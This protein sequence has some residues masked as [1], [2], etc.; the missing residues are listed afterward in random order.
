MPNKKM[1]TPRVTIVAPAQVMGPPPRPRRSRNIRTRLASVT[2]RAVRYASQTRRSSSQGDRSNLVHDDG[3]IEQKIAA[4]EHTPRTRAGVAFI[5]R[6]LNP[7]GED[8]TPGFVG[9]PDASGADSANLEHRDDFIL[10]TPV[11]LDN[12]EEQSTIVIFNTPYFM[13]HYIAI[14][15]FGAG[16]SSIDLQNTVNAPTA[17]QQDGPARYPNW[18]APTLVIN[19]AGVLIS[20]LGPAFEITFLV[21]TGFSAFTSA[22]GAG[23]RS[24]AWEW[25]R[26]WRYVC[27]GSTMHLNAPG[28]ANQGR[29]ISAAT[30]TESSWKNVNVVTGSGTPA[31]NVSVVARFT[32]SPPFQDNTLALQDANAHQD[33]AKKG[34]YTIQRHANEAIIWNEAEDVRPIW[35]TS[36][37]AV[38]GENGASVPSLP[39]LKI[40]GFDGNMGWIVQH[41]RGLSQQAS[42]HLKTRSVIAVTAP[43]TSPWALIMR[44]IVSKDQPALVLLKELAS[45]LP[46]SF[47][48]DYNDWGLL[49]KTILSCVARA[50]LPLARRALNRGLDVADSAFAGPAE[51]MPFNSSRGGYGDRSF[52][53]G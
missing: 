32:V 46:H 52:S 16:P 5:Q 25:F 4:M 35:R 17:A 39:F 36:T 49:A 28:L 45:A 20:Y 2:G 9:I 1:P 27:K 19:N 40:D 48:S 3:Q 43:G 10:N 22:A 53:T 30:A 24:Q 50:G 18:F 12:P 8:P 47:V 14:R 15:Y 37:A 34:E 26:K 44:P 23:V 38:V 41:V 6:V 51:N 31:T 13:V 7:C 11:S 42:L 33:L 21:P 29:V